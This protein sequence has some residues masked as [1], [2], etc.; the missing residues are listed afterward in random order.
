MK[1]E[2]EQIKINRDLSD[3]PIRCSENCHQLTI[4]PNTESDVIFKHKCKLTA[5][6]ITSYSKEHPCNHCNKLFTKQGQDKAEKLTLKLKREVQGTL[7]V[8][9]SNKCGALTIN[10]SGVLYCELS[11]TYPIPHGIDQKPIAVYCLHLY[12]TPKQIKPKR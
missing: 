1:F 10:E 7:A 2:T 3:V 9:C 5:T 12:K 8:R 4:D 11:P 6:P